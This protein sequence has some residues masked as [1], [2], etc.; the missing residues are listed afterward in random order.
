VFVVEQDCVFLDLD[1]RDHEPT[2]EHLWVA[3]D[4]G[5]GATLRLLSEGGSRWS[6]GR[7]AVRTDLRSQG[8]AAHLV[9]AGLDRLRELHATTVAI[10]A[11]AQLRSWYGQLGFTPSGPRYLED[12]ILHL[13]MALDRTQHPA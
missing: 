12:G 2:A 5:V 7:I 4:A 3:D 8:L 6:I 1:G 13:P 10:G 9:R 11:Q